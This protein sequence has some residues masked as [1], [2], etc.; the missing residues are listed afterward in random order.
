VSELLKDRRLALVDWN[1]APNNFSKSTTNKFSIHRRADFGD[2]SENL[3]VKRKQ[4]FQ[5]PTR[6]YTAFWV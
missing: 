5:P 6:Q 3:R 4:P 2:W 1:T